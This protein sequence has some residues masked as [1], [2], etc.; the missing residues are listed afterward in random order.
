MATIPDS[1]KDLL[2]GKNFAQIATLMPDGS[3]QVTPVWVDYDGKYVVINTADGR[4]KARNLDRDGRVAL[5]VFDHSNPYRYVQVRGKVALKTHDGA[6]EHIDR[7]AQKYLGQDRYP[8]RGEGETRVIYKIE[9]G[10]VQ[11]NG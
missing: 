6:D 1:H 3:P 5:A 4:Q 2:L 10:H 8:F 11:V 9:P 7:M